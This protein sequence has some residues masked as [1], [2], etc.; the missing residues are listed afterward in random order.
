MLEEKKDWVKLL[1][2]CNLGEMWVGWIVIWVKRE[3]GET[4]LG[5]KLFHLK[6]GETL[7]HL[8]LDE[9]LWVKCDWAN[10]YHT[11][12]TPKAMQHF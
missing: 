9:T 4:L 6:L 12:P 5:E 1:S 7:F 8:K 3:L 11:F 10:C 2:R